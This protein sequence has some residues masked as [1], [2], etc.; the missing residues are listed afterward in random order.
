MSYA[1]DRPVWPASSSWRNRAFV[2]SALPNPANMRI[3]QGRER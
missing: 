3:V 1:I 2:S